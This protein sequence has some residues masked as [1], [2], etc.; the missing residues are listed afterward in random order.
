MAARLI[1]FHAVHLD[2]AFTADGYAMCDLSVLIEGA[3]K[4]AEKQ[5]QEFVRLAKFRGVKFETAVKVAPPASE[6]CAFAEERDVDLII[7]ATHGRTGLKHLLMGSVAEQ[8]VRHARQPVL[9]VPSHPEMQNGE[10]ETRNPGGSTIYHTVR[11]KTARAACNRQTDEEKPKPAR[12]SISRAAQDKQVSRI[13]FALMNMKKL[14]IKNILVPIDFSKMSIQGI[15][16]AKRLGRSFGAAVHVAHVWEPLYAKGF[17][18]PAVAWGEFPAAYAEETRRQ[19]A[20][21]MKTVASKCGLSAD[22]T[23]FKEG[24][25]AFDVICGLA[26]E[27]PAD[28]LV[29]PT[30]ASRGI[31]R[32][33]LGSTAERLIQH[34]PC[35]ILVDRKSAAPLPMNSSRDVPA[36]Q[37][38]RVLVPVDFS[39]CSLEGL[40]YAIRFAE[41]FSAKITVLHVLDLGYAEP[42]YIGMPQGLTRF[43]RE[44]IKDAK[45]EM[46][47]FLGPVKFGRTKFGT[48]FVIGTPVE[49]ISDFAIS[50]DCDLIITSTHGLTGFKHVLIGSIAEHLVRQSRVPILVVPS[51]PELRRSNLAG[52]RKSRRRPQTQRTRTGGLRVLKDKGLAKGHR[53]R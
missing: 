38:K 30:R 31:R 18:A 39:S 48:E 3:R 53:D 33:F 17:A 42:M 15:E 20:E 6:I 51:H 29:V 16:T 8:V 13:A 4:N 45:E 43:A 26:A 27:I 5:M 24:A 44:A 46:R 22:M 47:R 21:Q 40:K 2:L 32:F 49:Q 12:T 52:R 41:A 25:P 9:V 50:N 11:K 7:T 1:V 35:P 23:H 36:L 19:L 14:G 28:L 34:S 37:I 10:I